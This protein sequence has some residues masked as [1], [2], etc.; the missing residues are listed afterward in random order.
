MV[1]KMRN[2]SVGYRTELWQRLTVEIGWE[3]DLGQSQAE[4]I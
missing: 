4:E 2:V 3:D 1:A